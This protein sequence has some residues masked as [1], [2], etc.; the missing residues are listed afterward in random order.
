MSFNNDKDPLSRLDINGVANRIVASIEDKVDAYKKKWGIRYDTVVSKLDIIIDSF[1]NLTKYLSTM[2]DI[3]NATYKI[4][5]SMK[6]DKLLEDNTINVAVLITYHGEVT[7]IKNGE[8]LNVKDPKEVILDY[9]RNET[10]SL[11]INT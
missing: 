1:Q 5:E 10:P 2:E 8:K 4:V 9:E 11:T 3:T 6:E 7:V